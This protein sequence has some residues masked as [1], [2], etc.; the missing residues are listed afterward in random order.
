[1]VKKNGNLKII[2]IYFL[3]MLFWYFCFF[4][5]NIFNTLIYWFMCIDE[6]IYKN[7]DRENGRERE[8]GK[9]KL[10]GVD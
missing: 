1:M 2:N 8:G 7:W 3:C 9:K 10:V 5:F 6:E 4:F